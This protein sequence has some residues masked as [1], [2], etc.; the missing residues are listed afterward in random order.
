[1]TG[2]TFAPAEGCYLLYRKA[3]KGTSKEIG[4]AKL[5]S[6]RHPSLDAAV[7]EATRLLTLF[8]DSTFIVMQE[9][10][11]VKNRGDEA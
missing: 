2:P 7:T 9:I 1:M 5:P 11:T 3:G 8:P 6:F 4:G 10:G